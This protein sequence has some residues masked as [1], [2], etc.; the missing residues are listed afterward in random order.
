MCG[1]KA[2]RARG[3][4]GGRKP[5]LGPKEKREIEALLLDPK[6]TVKDVAERYG[7]SRNTIYQHIDVK[8]INEAMNKKRI[9]Q[10]MEEESHG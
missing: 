10:I 4:K 3:R 2:A 6:I 7:V 8:A 5:V 1:L 9:Q